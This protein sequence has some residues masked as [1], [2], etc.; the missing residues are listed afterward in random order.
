MVML[1]LVLV[2]YL[3]VRALARAQWSYR[4]YLDGAMTMDCET[5]IVT[6]AERRREAGTL[7]CSDRDSS[8]RSSF[9]LNV[10]ERGMNLQCFKS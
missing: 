1:V 8:M 10:S 9:L 2:G 6:M 7:G 4:R 3:R 5:R